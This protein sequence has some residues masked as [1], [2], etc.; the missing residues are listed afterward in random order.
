MYIY[1]SIGIQLFYVINFLQSSHMYFSN[2]NFF[3]FSNVPY[4]NMHYF[5]KPPLL[6]QF[7]ENEVG[8]VNFSKNLKMPSHNLFFD[9]VNYKCM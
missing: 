5:L 9:F 3:K 7:I 4:E 6:Q 1:C 8:I 2:S